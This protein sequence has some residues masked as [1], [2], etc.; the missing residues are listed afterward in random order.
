MAVT[1]AIYKHQ[2][3]KRLE[4]EKQLPVLKQSKVGRIMGQA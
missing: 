4:T 2:E 1:E 3:H